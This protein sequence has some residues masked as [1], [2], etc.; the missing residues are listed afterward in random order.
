MYPSEKIFIVMFL[1][2]LKKMGVSKIPYDNEAFYKGVERM[3]DYF[4]KNKE[5][6]GKY[7]NEIAMLFL[8]NSFGGVFS[9]FKGGMDRQNG[10]LMSFDNPHYVSAEI[11][12]DASGA[13]Y[14]LKQN[15]HE[16]SETVIRGFCTAFCEGAKVVYK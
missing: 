15:S 9:E 4:N 16:M 8:R 13:D 1:A 2:S 14:I 3:F 11:E 6:L 7:Q 10:D 12:L 5:Q